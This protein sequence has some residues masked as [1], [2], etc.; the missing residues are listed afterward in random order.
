M[1]FYQTTCA[2][3]FI[4]CFVLYVSFFSWMYFS[5][6]FSKLLYVPLHLSMGADT[7]I[8]GFEIWPWSDFKPYTKKANIYPHKLW[9]KLSC[10]TLKN[11]TVQSDE[12]YH[13]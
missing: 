5:L 9:L 4:F 11:K 1:N 7:T 2:V 10:V 3:F 6:Y 13:I 8:P 12:V